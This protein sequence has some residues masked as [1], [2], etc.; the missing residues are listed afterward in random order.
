MMTLI[1]SSTRLHAP[2]ARECAVPSLPFFTRTLTYPPSTSLTRYFHGMART[3]LAPFHTRILPHDLVSPCRTDPGPLARPPLFFFKKKDQSKNTSRTHRAS[4]IR[5]C[6][7]IQKRYC[8]SKLQ[9]LVKLSQ[10]TIRNLIRIRPI[11]IQYINISSAPASAKTPLHHI[12]LK[13][14]S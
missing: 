13:A 8:A 10:L 11:V 14:D 5:E 6:H 9:A 4:G 3:R 2:C 12:V 1:S 7:A